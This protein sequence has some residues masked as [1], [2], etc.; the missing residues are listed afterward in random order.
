MPSLVSVPTSADAAA[1]IVPSPPPTITQRVA[2]LGDRSA[3]HLALAALD[4]LDLAFDSRLRERRGDFLADVSGSAAAAPPPRLIR[5]GTGSMQ[6]LTHEADQVAPF[7]GDRSVDSGAH[8][9]TS[10]MRW[11]V[12]CD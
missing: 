6:R 3:P 5:T 8:C 7:F 4:E 12:S 9:S 11:A 10:P 2:A 1:P